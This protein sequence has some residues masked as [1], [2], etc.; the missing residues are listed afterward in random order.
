MVNIRGDENMTQLMRVPEDVEEEILE[1][2]G[3]VGIGIGEK[4]SDNRVVSD[5][6][7]VVF[8]QK[9][10]DVKDLDEDD[11]VPSA[12]EIDDRDVE[13][14]VQEV[15]DVETLIAESG[16]VQSPEGEEGTE[17]VGE[18]T[19]PTALP[20]QFDPQSRTKKWRP[21][22][23]GVS[24]GHPNVTAGTL[25]TPP[26]RTQNGRS[27]FLT[28]THVAAPV[29]NSSIGD[30]IIQPGTAD[31]GTASDRIGTL[32]ERTEIEPKSSGRKNRTDS[33]LVEV[34]ADHLQHDV[35]ELWENLRGWTEP[36]VGRTYTKSG[37]TTGVTSGRLTARNAT[38]EISGFFPSEPAVFEGLDVYTGMAAGGDSGSLIG[39]ERND[40]FYGTSLLFAG[41]PTITLGIPMT[42]VQAHHGP[43]SPVQH[44]N[45]V[46][47]HD[48]RITGTQ[49]RS[50]IDPGQ[51]QK[52]FTFNWPA[53]YLVDWHVEPTTTDGKLS[54]S[55]EIERTSNG[56]KTYWITVENVGSVRTKFEGKYALF[57]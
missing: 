8:V 26:L 44:Q 21:A 55:V 33:A 19:E 7:V 20:D 18:P 9:K 57:R 49:W 15:G 1:K 27:V 52:W 13:T 41:S 54:T 22:P 36:A 37:R 47:A 16:M 39:V 32:V 29:N 43:L 31:G 5:E 14:D 48:L 11:I 46:R 35:F 2:E 24:V 4:V 12:V 6:S 45:V 50:V 56:L 38:F 42:N 53:E 23:A 34:E 51:K 10:V 17:E 30:A 25:G 3:V 28:N 40:G